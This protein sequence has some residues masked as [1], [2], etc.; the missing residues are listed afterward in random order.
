ML[1]NQ[2]VNEM[3]TDA[4]KSTTLRRF[5]IWAFMLVVVPLHAQQGTKQWNLDEIFGSTHF[6]LKTLSATQWVDGGKKI[7][8]LETDTLTG[9]RNVHLYTISNRRGA[10][11]VDGSLLVDSPGSEPMRIGSYEWSKDGKRVLITG[12]LPARRTKTGGNFGVF[13]VETK[14]F[15]R[16]TDTEEEQAIIKFSPDG[17]KI[18]FTRSNNLFVMDIASGRE[19]QLTFDGTAD[20]IN[21]RFDWVYEEEFSIIDGWEWSP[22]S[23]RIAFWRLDQT[24][25][26]T[27][28]L[29][30]YPVDSQHAGIEI[31]KYPKTGEENPLVRI[32][33]V[34]VASGETRWLDLGENPDIYIPR[35]I[36]TPKPDILSVMRMNRGQDTLELMLANVATGAMRTILVETDTAWLEIDDNLRFLERSEQFIWTSWRDG[37]MHIYLYN[38][39]G[40]LARQLTRG[41]WE[42]TGVDAVDERRKLVFFTATQVSPMERH[43]YSVKFDGTGLRRL[44]REA[45]TH[46]VKFSPDNLVYMDTYSST[47][48]PPRITLHSNEGARVATL[49]ENSTEV[50]R[51]YPLARQEFFTFRI[52]SGENLNAWMMKPVDFDSTK[53]YPVL[54]YVYGGPGSQMVVDRWGG[55][56]YLWFNLLAQQGYI[57]VSVD[58]RGT[59]GRGT[60]F[61]QQ[62]HN[63]LGLL[64]TEDFI[65]TARYLGTLPHVD[66]ARIGIW[67]WS[68]G[69]YMT[70]MALTLGAEV[71]KTGIA[72]A[73]VTDFKYYDTIWTE[74]YMDTPQNNP[75]GY[76]ET[77]AI[78]HASKL[79]GNL[80]LI[81]GTTDDNVHWQNVIAFVDELIKHNKQVQ[82][83]FYPGKDHRIANVSVHLYTLMT[84]YLREKL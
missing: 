16:L 9:I 49:V 36:W 25:V 66:P 37:F 2:R 17:R 24:N 78:T 20:I 53:R 23:K 43:L 64:E 65:A 56:R 80:L 3:T 45:G 27:F 48:I 74:R 57:I 75:E 26:S 33:V 40:T 12:T 32:G 77:S 58:N 19:T 60:A 61:M 30:R 39:D 41:D 44:T 69:G 83:M 10:I 81:H 6:Q 52:P 13:D 31:M 34:T 50:L 63:R 11:A 21:G 54:M 38:M 22:D 68:G 55:A 47:T 46:A 1:I 76:R 62:T 28:P 72:V 70:C 35:V 8:Y 59:G 71:F 73:A 84:N 14:T 15:R 4:P 7:S 29:V 18:G 67:G 51:E 42:V 82:T 79:K 5:S